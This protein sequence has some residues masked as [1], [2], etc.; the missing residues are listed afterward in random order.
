MTTSQI[1]L[2]ILGRVL[3]F[4]AGGAIAGC[5]IGL[6]GGGTAGAVLSAI[7]Y[8][9]EKSFGI[10]LFDG[11]SIGGGIGAQLGAF[12]GILAFSI[13]ALLQP[14]RADLRR[15]FRL[16]VQGALFW[17][18]AGTALGATCGTLVWM[19]LDQFIV[20]PSGFKL[21]ELDPLFRMLL[22]LEGAQKGFYLG[23]IAGFIVGFF[24]GAILGGTGR[25]QNLTWRSIVNWV[26]PKDL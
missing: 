6:V 1:A 19:I 17:T 8:N 18:I 15:F 14:A 7:I 26:S 21:A 9:T 3:I 11:G 24:A 25:L 10:T 4:G 5:V 12:V 20:M 22:F 23:S 13:V 2:R 16:A